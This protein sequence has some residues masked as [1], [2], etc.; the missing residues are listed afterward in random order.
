MTGL[1]GTTPGRPSVY[2]HSRRQSQHDGSHH[3]FCVVGAMERTGP[4]MVWRVAMAWEICCCDGLVGP[5]SSYACARLLDARTLRTIPTTIG[6]CISLVEVDLS[7]NLLSE[8]PETFSDLRNLKALYLGN[9]GL[10]SL[11]NMLFKMCSQL[12]ILDLHG[13]S[14]TIELL[15]QFEGWESFDERRRL[16]HQKQLDFRVNGSADFDEGADK[17]W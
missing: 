11:P 1:A 4:A 9:N 6:G 16:K 15:R 5:P 2:V 3:V 7:C 13:T 14:I 17:D 8:L 12:S 10:K